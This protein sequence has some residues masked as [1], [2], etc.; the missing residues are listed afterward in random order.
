MNSNQT[1]CPV[2]LF[3][4]VPKIIKETLNMSVQNRYNLDER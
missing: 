1:L 2:L 4:V 3:T